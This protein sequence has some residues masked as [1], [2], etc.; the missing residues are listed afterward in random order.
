MTATA[1]LPNKKLV[2]FTEKLSF[3]DGDM[4]FILDSEDSYIL[5]K[6]NKTLMKGDQ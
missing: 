6:I 1:D 4:S 5:K 2:D 3:V